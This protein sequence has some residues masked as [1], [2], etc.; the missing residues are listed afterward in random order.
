MA[1]VNYVE[2][3]WGLQLY[4]A[5][6]RRRVKGPAQDRVQLWSVS[7]GSLVWGPPC[8]ALWMKTCWLK[9]WRSWRAGDALCSSMWREIWPRVSLCFGLLVTPIAQLRTSG[10]FTLH[11][12]LPVF[13]S[14]LNGAAVQYCLGW[15]LQ[16][17]RMDL[18]H[19]SGKTVY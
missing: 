19:H 15:T 11:L 10:H 17:T 3:S 9:L 13:W 1:I 4:P 8:P 12:L 5:A 6:S 2:I 16:A 14:S 18:L 7:A